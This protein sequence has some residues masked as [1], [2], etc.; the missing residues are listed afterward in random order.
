MPWYVNAVGTVADATTFFIGSIFFTSASFLQ[1]LQAQN[2]AMAPGVAPEMEFGRLALWA[3]RPA[4]R[5]WLSAATQFPGTLAFNVS[6]LLAIDA[7]LTVQQVDRLVW[8]PDFVGSV[9]FLVAS[10][11]GILAV[12]GRFR[13]WRPHDPWWGIAWTNMVGSIF[14]MASAIGAYL[15]PATGSEVDPR[16]ASLGTFAGAICFLVG[17]LWL[18]P[19]WRRSSA[20]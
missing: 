19:A 6:T 3:P 11:Y 5:G 1:L 20:G 17:A 12:V 9:L 10:G 2:P 7:S 4:D 8:R 14:F 16:W 18:L 13:V 15:L